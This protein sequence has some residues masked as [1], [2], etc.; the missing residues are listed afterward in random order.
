[1]SKIK[2]AG[3]RNILKKQNHL[4]IWIEKFENKNT[5]TICRL[6]YVGSRVIEDNIME[7]KR[8]G[9]TIEYIKG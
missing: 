4:N 6:K 3:R 1:M 7:F 9:K 5:T 8:N 2:Y